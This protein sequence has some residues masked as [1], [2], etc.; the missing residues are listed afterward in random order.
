MLR[1]QRRPLGQA[2]SPAHARSPGTFFEVSRARIAARA[3]SVCCC[4]AC[5]HLAASCIGRRAPPH[6]P[7]L[8]APLMSAH[9]PACRRCDPRA[10]PPPV[11]PLGQC[12]HSKL[13]KITCS[14]ACVNVCALLRALMVGVAAEYAQD[15]RERRGAARGLPRG[16]QAKQLWQRAA[17]VQQLARACAMGQSNTAGVPS[18]WLSRCRTVHMR[19]IGATGRG[20]GIIGAACVVCWRTL[21]AAKHAREVRR[22]G[23]MVE[24]HS[25]RV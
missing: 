23:S 10:P 3:S 15:V 14:P 25:L 7:L 17:P 8:P 9:S 11:G 2:A 24:P 6:V 19:A 16:A 1:R 21:E 12:E 22:G 18:T 20:C 4:I 13:C 5:S